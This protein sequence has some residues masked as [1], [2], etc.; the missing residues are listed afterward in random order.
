MEDRTSLDLKT[1]QGRWSQVRFEE[2]GFVEPSDSH[3][4]P[5]A[6]MTV[7]DTS[8]HVGVPGQDT[9]LEGTFA[10]D[11]TTSPKTITWTDAIGDDAGKS[12]SA[13]YELSDIHFIFVAA[14]EDM[15]T[16][17]DFSTGPGL[18]LRSFTRHRDL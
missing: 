2:N 7:L 4:A 6:I 9:I 3:S 5:G 17:T 16:P 18:T 11:A 8:F 10:L 1:L 13:I 14:D 15:P 12:F